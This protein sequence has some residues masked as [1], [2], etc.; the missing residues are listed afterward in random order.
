MEPDAFFKPMEWNGQERRVAGN[1]PGRVGVFVDPKVPTDKPES[2]MQQAAPGTSA[3][4]QSQFSTG[5]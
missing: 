3:T 2:C 1:Y 5:G 4:E